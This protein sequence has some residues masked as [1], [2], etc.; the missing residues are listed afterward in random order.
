MCSHSRRSASMT[1]PAIGRDSIRVHELQRT[2]AISYPAVQPTGLVFF[3]HPLYA[4]AEIWCSEV[5]VEHHV[6]ALGFVAICPQGRHDPRNNATNWRSFVGVGYDGTLA[7]DGYEDLYFLDALAAWAQEHMAIP[8]NRTFLFGCS[9]GGSLAY[10]IACE[11][12]ERFDGLGTFSQEW[13]DP[14][15]GYGIRGAQLANT[16]EAS[17]RRRCLPS[18]RLPLWSNVGADDEFY[19]ATAGASWNYYSTKVL[20][21][22]DTPREA[23]YGKAPGFGATCHERRKCGD[24]TTRTRLCSEPRVAHSCAISHHIPVAWR[25]L[26]Q[27]QTREND[28]R[29]PW[30]ALPEELPGRERKQ[31]RP[32][33]GAGKNKGLRHHA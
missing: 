14:F 20:G 16:P 27:S 15:A 22:T 19:A 10:R 13:F 1:L 6:Q 8:A 2:F 21:C 25:F 7:A 12:P 23:P 4:R 18:K 3:L 17:E 26:M 30:S 31:H 29:E 28:E 11:R 32:W 33:L 5:G 24:P 9:A